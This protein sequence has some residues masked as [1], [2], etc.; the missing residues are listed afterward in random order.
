LI[1]LLVVIAII[2][3]LIGLLVPAVQQVRLA[4]ARTQSQNNLK[5]LG[6]ALHSAHDA[7]KAFPPIYA[8][9][10]GTAYADVPNQRLAYDGPYAA[11]NVPGDH[12]PAE[13]Y[14][15][16]FYLCL[17]PYVEQ[18]NVAFNHSVYSNFAVGQPRIMSTTIPLLL[19]PLD[20]TSTQTPLSNEAGGGYTGAP[21]QG[22]LALT[23]YAPNFRVFGKRF[24]PFT[25][26]WYTAPNLYGIANNSGA[27]AMR[28]AGITDGVSNTIF[29]C[30]KMAVCGAAPP[31]DAG[32]SLPAVTAWGYSGG[33][34]GTACFA[35]LDARLSANNDG[36]WNLPQFNPTPANCN[37]LTVQSF[38]S[39][40]INV[41]LGDGSVRT[42]SSAVDQATWSAAITPTGGEPL[43]LDP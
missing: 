20:P 15:I 27:G 31:A 30:E 9:W 33:Q 7:R 13:H 38:S 5:Q 17:L 35:G 32:S 42:I 43:N 16:T 8:G 36:P 14:D 2:A 19:S 6:L 1:E 22:P 3:V 29:L 11:R 23:S 12:N 10:Y 26:G 24:A 34:Y 39:A 21:S 41:C 25:A 37:W 28:I 40:G 4:A 18:A